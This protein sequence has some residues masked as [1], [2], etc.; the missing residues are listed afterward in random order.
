M[1]E[2]SRRNEAKHLQFLLEQ[3][4]GLASNM[5]VRLAGNL[6]LLPLDGEKRGSV[7]WECH[8]QNNIHVC[9]SPCTILT[10]FRSEHLT[11]VRI[12]MLTAKQCSVLLITR[13]EGNSC[14]HRKSR[15]PPAC[16]ICTIARRAQASAAGWANEDGLEFACK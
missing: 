5:C 9:N 2:F 16:L 6:R 7:Q 14:V 12:K 15:S 8:Q 3:M 4:S 10:A 13:A 11:T 1:D